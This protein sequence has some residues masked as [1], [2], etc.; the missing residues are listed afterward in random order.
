MPLIHSYSYMYANLTLK[1]IFVLPVSSGHQFNDIIF[2]D[3]SLA[4][5]YRDPQTYTHVSSCSNTLPYP[6]PTSAAFSSINSH[7]GNQLNHRDDLES[8]TYLLIYLAH[9]SLPWLDLKAPTNSALLWCKDEIMPA[10]LCRSLP[11]S[12]STLLLYLC[13]LSFMQKPN[14]AY[15]M[16]L[17]HDLHTDATVPSHIFPADLKLS[18][19]S[20]WM[21][22][23]LPKVTLLEEAP[24]KHWCNTA[25]FLMPSPIK[26]YID[27]L[28]VEMVKRLT[29]IFSANVFPGKC[30]ANNF[31]K[32]ICTVSCALTCQL[33]VC[34]VCCIHLYHKHSIWCSVLPVPL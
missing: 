13:G 28:C 15:I 16:S 32:I 33:L 27:Q 30:I 2:F 23:T 20:Y 5:L 18:K 4:W 21:D 24:Q 11:L 12:F 22:N 26:T 25:V 6:T 9:G 3:F 10:D 8:L 17:F 19:V 31:C 7:L 34:Q 29:F 14:Y 1:N